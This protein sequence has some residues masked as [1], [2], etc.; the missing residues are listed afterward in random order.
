SSK[1]IKGGALLVD[2]KIF[3]R[4]YDESL[5]VEENLRRLRAANVFG[6]ASRARVA[7]ILPIF[8]QRFCDDGALA[9]PLRKL[10]RRPAPDTVLDRVLYFHAGRQDPLLRDFACRFVFERSRGSDS[11]IRPEESSM[12]IRELLAQ[13][14]QAWGAETLSRVTQG[15]LSTLRDFGVLTGA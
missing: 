8:R 14:K 2:S 10:A 7:E 12:F 15:L 3:L 9:R 11:L 6:K 4:V 1:I 13:H 5:S